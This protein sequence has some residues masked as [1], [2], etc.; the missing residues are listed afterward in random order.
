MALTFYVTVSH[1]IQLGVKI[2]RGAW[3][4]RNQCGHF[5]PELLG[6]LWISY[7]SAR[8][9]ANARETSIVILT[10][11]VVVRFWVVR[12]PDSGLDTELSK[13]SGPH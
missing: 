7:S 12:P 4:M 3:L 5:M 1:N 9:I 6:M 8:E 2:I 13:D 10:Y 11:L